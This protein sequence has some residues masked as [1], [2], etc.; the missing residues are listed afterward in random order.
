MRLQDCVL[1]VDQMMTGP[2]KRTEPDQY[3]LAAH[4]NGVIPEGVFKLYCSANYLSYGSAPPFFSDSRNAVFGYF[5]MLMGGVLEFFDDVEE[6]HSEFK[7]QSDLLYD[8]AKKIRGI[9][10]SVDA[11]KHESRAFRRLTMS[12]AGSLDVFAD[13]VALF[14]TGQINGLSVGKSDFSKIVSWVE[15]ALPP[16]GSIVTPPEHFRRHLHKVMQGFLICAGPDQE[17]ID[18]LNLFRNKSAHLGNQMFP[19]SA[20]HDRTVTFYH[21]LPREWPEILEAQIEPGDGGV[22][23]EIQKRLREHFEKT[24]MHEDI[25]SFTDGL[26][27]RVFN[28]LDAGFEVLNDAYGQLKSSPLNPQ[29][30][31]DLQ[32]NHRS[33]KFQHF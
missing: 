8:P 2:M 7:R 3:W 14:F 31:D 12:L 28:L 1:E 16:L 17:W 15:S 11:S 29:V 25:V 4:D 24:L 6:L 26:R 10:F 5:R 9:P 23:A 13:V 19:L 22:T 32:R 20:F 18:M 21:F 27:K 30:L 33:Y